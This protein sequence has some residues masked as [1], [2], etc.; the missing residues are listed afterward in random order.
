MDPLI[1]RATGTIPVIDQLLVSGSGGLPHALPSFI[2]LSFNTLMFVFCHNQ[3][4]ALHLC[5]MGYGLC[6][7]CVCGSGCQIAECELELSDAL[8]LVLVQFFFAFCYTYNYLT[9]N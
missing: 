8:D 3:Q 1:W 4:E 6:R 2:P 7:L 9:T 5:C